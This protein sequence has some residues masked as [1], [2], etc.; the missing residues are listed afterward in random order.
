MRDAV[1]GANREFEGWVNAELAHAHLGRGDVELAE[2]TARTAVARAHA[3]HNRFDEIRGHL[4]LTHT[5]LRRADSSTL[6][7]AE[8]SLDQ[9]AELVSTSAA[10]VYQPEIGKLRAQVS[11]QRGDKPAA[12]REI[13][14][15]RRL[16]QE[17]GA[18]TQAERLMKEVG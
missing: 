10:H 17:M 13:E 12:R 16:Y 18:T 2:R 5:L 9:A 4:A 15:A 6:D 1:S 8:Q 3:Q 7:R 14:E 11:L